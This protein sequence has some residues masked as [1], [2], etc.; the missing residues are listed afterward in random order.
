MSHFRILIFVALIALSGTGA[1]PAQTPDHPVMKQGVPTY[2]NPILYADYSDPDVIRVG[3]DFYCVASSFNCSPGLPVLHSRDLVHW[4]I[5]TY[6]L[7]L[8]YPLSYYSTPRHGDGV[9]APSIRYNDGGYFIYYGDPDNGIYVLKASRPE[10]PWKGPILVRA[11]KGWI[12]PCPLWD[13]HGYAYIVHA[14]AKSREGF[15]SILTLHR[16]VSE[17]TM[18]TDDGITIYD[19]HATQPTIEGPKLYKRNGW[20]YIFA[21]AGGVKNGWQTVLRSK[22]IL[23]PYEEKVVLRQGSTSVNGPHQGAWVEMENGDSWFVHFQDAGT[24]GRI[25]HLEPVLWKNDWPVIGTNIDTAGC[26]EPVMEWSMPVVTDAAKQDSLPTSDEFDDGKPGLQWQWEGNMKDTWTSPADQPGSLRL[27]AMATPA[28]ARNLRDLPN[29]LLQKI[30]SPVFTITARV[31]AHFN[32]DGEKGGIVIM[33]SDYASLAIIKDGKSYIVSQKEC[34]NAD[35]T[36]VEVEKGS[37]M[38][39]RSTIDLRMEYG[40]GEICR[41]SYRVNDGAFIPLGSAFHAVAGRWMGAKV[42]LFATPARSFSKPGFISVDWFRV[43]K[44]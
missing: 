43:E 20:Y 25:L 1:V 29:L 16:M 9:W 42:G 21:P 11:A 18:I 15:N 39:D 14:H 22:S 28:N 8:I 19:G 36:A 38:I 3:A 24:A 35:S 7:P 4:S 26:G 5:L 40:T 23:G 41:F 13:E 17:G 27:N 6:A 10:G 44:Q 30:P 32:N 31:T 37:A 34:L 33:G 12:D 2:T